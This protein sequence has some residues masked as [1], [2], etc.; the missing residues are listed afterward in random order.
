MA[1]YNVR[2]GGVDTA[3][4]NCAATSFSRTTNCWPMSLFYSL[5]NNVCLNYFV[6]Y[7]W[8]N[9]EDGSITTRVFEDSRKTP[10]GLRFERGYCRSI[11]I[12]NASKRRCPRSSERIR[13]A[14]CIGNDRKTSTYCCK[15]LQRLVET[16]VNLLIA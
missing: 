2:K 8:N 16:A 13:C 14:Y 9:D 10:L 15:C 5:I 12:Y 11:N 7:I 6:I 3:D 4:K 1:F